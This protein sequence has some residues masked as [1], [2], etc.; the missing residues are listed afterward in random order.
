MCSN[1]D[2][3][4]F[5]QYNRRSLQFFS[6]LPIIQHILQIHN[7]LI[8]LDEKRSDIEFR[9]IWFCGGGFGCWTDCIL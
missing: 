1:T 8:K 2:L 3:Y 6:K 4:L 7:R 5:V 9:K